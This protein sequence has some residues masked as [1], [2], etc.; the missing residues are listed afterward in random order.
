MEKDGGG[1]RAGVERAGGGVEEIGKKAK[2]RSHTAFGM[3]L[4]FRCYS[5]VNEQPG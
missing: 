4:K 2:S 1:Q 5:K 3:W